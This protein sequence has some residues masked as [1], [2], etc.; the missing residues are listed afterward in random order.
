MVFGRVVID[1][2]V[3]FPKKDFL[4][5]TF[6]LFFISSGHLSLQKMKQLN[7]KVS[8]AKLKTLEHLGLV[9]L[10]KKGHVR[11]L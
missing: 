11:L 8:D 3:I 10:D 1:R 9:D 7:M 6:V 5:F 4:K 2:I